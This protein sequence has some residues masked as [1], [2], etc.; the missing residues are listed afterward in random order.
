[1]RFF[2]ILL[3]LGVALAGCATDAPAAD[4]MPPATDPGISDLPALMAALPPMD[5]DVTSAVDWWEHLATQF[6]K[7]DSYTPQNDAIRDHLVA[8]LKGLGMQVEVRS[9]QALPRDPLAPPVP[10]AATEVDAIIATKPGVKQA[11]G[12]D[13]RIG[14]VSHYDTQAATIHGAYDD[15]SGVATSFHICKAFMAVQL[16]KTLTCI[17]FDAEEQGLVASA[18]YVE[19]IADETDDYVYDFIVGY[20][21]TGI[22]WPGH[23][24]KMYVMTGPADDVPLLQPFAQDIMHGHLGYPQDGVEVLPTHD[25]NSDERRFKEAGIPIYRFAG[26]RHAADY[27]QYHGPDDTVQHVYDFVGGRSN[28]EAGFT[29]IVEGSYHLIWALDKTDRAGLIAQYA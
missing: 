20:D 16:N 24:W 28:W 2:T 14:L 5:F 29:T 18:R 19:D 6:P 4:A 26:G 15:K 12:V 9:Y 13:H 22:N 11:D 7:H 10:T 17:M 25:R 27:D 23:A 1:M 8:E 21:M 3:V